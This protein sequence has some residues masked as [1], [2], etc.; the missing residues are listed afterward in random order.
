MIKLINP[1]SKGFTLIEI[2]VVL[3]IISLVLTGVI[4]VANTQMA[5]GKISAS[6]QRIEAIKAALINFIANNN[7][8]P[9]PANPAL[10]S[11]NA[12]Y[13]VEAATPGT[14]TGAVNFGAGVAA[15]SRGVVPWVTLGLADNIAL[16]GWG[17]RFS[18]QVRRTQTNLT[19]VTIPSLTGNITVLNAAAGAV[20]NPTNPAVAII[21]S[22]GENGAGAYLP[23]TGTRVNPALTGA[24]EQ[25]N[26]DNDIIYVDKA[27]SEI[28]ANPFDD[29]IMW[30][31]P[32]D[33]LTE[34][35]R[36]S[37][38]ATP[39][40][41]VNDK[42]SNIKNVLIGYIVA[43]RANP[44]GV[45]DGPNAGTISCSCVAVSAPACTGW[46]AGWRT[47]WRRL[48]YADRAPGACGGTLNDGISD[49]NCLSGNV[50]WSTLGITQASATDPWGNTLRYTVDTT[51]AASSAI[52]G[53]CTATPT[54]T[55]TALLLRS[56]GA[57]GIAATADDITLTVTV[58]QLRGTL[59]ANGITMDP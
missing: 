36:T 18:Y 47:Y 20:I 5:N 32:S 11:S 12:S 17:R 49:N 15:N 58:N 44:D 42:I 16:D 45:P 13:G 40:G 28:V 33:L 59:T 38:V 14:C 39:T 43:D 23:Y 6:N 57:D 51:L 48:P 37:V 53:M 1:I 25:E 26:T 22:H 10:P 54:G 3:F 9:C 4:S 46:R 7:R 29:I 50:P 52:S 8:L 41:S 2:A 31:T 35:Q 55:N 24:D 21:L 27:Y 34:L 56:L 30:L 19:A